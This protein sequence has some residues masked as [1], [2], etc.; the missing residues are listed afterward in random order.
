MKKLLASIIVLLIATTMSCAQTQMDS[1]NA[2]NTTD[3]KKEVIVPTE[4]SASFEM[5]AKF[6]RIKRKKNNAIISI[7]SYRKSLNIKV[8]TVKIC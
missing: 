8:K 6:L 4:V 1:N 2:V 3:V 5:R 7:K